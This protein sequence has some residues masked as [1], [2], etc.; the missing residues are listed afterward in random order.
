MHPPS[1][2]QRPA[3]QEKA[4]GNPRAWLLALLALAALA[5][6]A[7]WMPHPKAPFLEI[8]PEGNIRIAPWREQKRDKAIDKLRKAEQY[9]LFAIENGKYPCFSC[10]NED[11]I[12]LHKGEVWK[13]GV[14][15]NGASIRYGR[16]LSTMKVEYARQFVGSLLECREEELRKIFDYPILPE[17]A[18]RTKPLIRPP[19]NK[20][21]Q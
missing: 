4:H 21:D 7:H 2:T 14:T 13:Y 17:N 15:Y 10:Q 5:A 12:F 8:D 6:L 20:L 3:R 1:P 19:G 11:S 9:A 16:K 18:T